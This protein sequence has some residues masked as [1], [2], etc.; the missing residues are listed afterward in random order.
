MSPNSCAFI[1]LG[2]YNSKDLVLQW[3]MPLGLSCV[4]PLALL[5]GIPF[6]PGMRAERHDLIRSC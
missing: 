3:R 5:I 1:S 6:I 4:G 2:T